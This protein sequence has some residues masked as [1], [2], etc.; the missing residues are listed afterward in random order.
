MFGFFILLI[1]SLQD[2]FANG[3]WNTYNRPWD[4]VKSL[5]T[6]KLLTDKVIQVNK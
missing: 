4:S 6:E 5:Y 2:L 3:F 1:F